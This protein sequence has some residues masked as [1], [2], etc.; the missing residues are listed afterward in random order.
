[1]LRWMF[2]FFAA[3]L[4]LLSVASLAVW[5]RSYHALLFKGWTSVATTFRVLTSPLLA[6]VLLFGLFSAPIILLRSQ[7]RSRRR[8]LGCCIRCGYDLRATTG[9]CPECGMSIET[10]AEE[11]TR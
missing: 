9:R 4:L 11:A 7:R 10:K 2:I 3:M 5:E 8:E 6:W 1:M